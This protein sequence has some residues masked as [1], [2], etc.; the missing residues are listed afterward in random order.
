MRGALRCTG[1]DGGPVRCELVAFAGAGGAMLLTME[2]C[3]EGKGF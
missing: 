3:G 2:M 1:C